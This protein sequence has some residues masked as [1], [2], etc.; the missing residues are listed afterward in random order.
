MPVRLT[1]V[2]RD[3]LATLR[4]GTGCLE[5]GPGLVQPRTAAALVAKGL[6]EWT[7]TAKWGDGPTYRAVRL[8]EPAATPPEAQP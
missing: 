6:C 5:V 7:Q 3:T 4:D 2:Q 8:A 1:R